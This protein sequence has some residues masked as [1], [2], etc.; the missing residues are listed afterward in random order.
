MRGSVRRALV[1]T[2][3]RRPREAAATGPSCDAYA[4]DGS[5]IVT[6]GH[7]AKEKVPVGV[8]LGGAG[9]NPTC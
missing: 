1:G 2:P 7:G 9:L 8:P 6:Q 5:W 4:N 3:D